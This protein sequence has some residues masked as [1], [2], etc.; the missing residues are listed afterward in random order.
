MSWLAAT[1]GVNETQSLSSAKKCGT[2]IFLPFKIRPN[3]PV[4]NEQQIPSL[5]LSPI[6]KT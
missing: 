5:A 2:R 4:P 6:V 1:T 3:Q